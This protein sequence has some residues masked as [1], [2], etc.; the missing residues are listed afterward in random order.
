MHQLCKLAR[1]CDPQPN[2]KT[3]QK[4][5]KLSTEIFQNKMVVLQNQDLKTTIT[6]NS[7]KKNK[8]KNGKGFKNDQNNTSFKKYHNLKYKPSIL[9]KVE[10]N[11]QQLTH[12]QSQCPRHRSKR[13]AVSMQLFCT[14]SCSPESMERYIQISL[15]LR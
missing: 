10:E 14:V 8:R 9:D 7:F 11:N 5:K 12:S 15:D 3:K 13:I 6:N 1:K 4:Q 2:R